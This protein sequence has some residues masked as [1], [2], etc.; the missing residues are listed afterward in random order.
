MTYPFNIL[1]KIV[2]HC[3]VQQQNALVLFIGLINKC[4]MIFCNSVYID[5]LIYYNSSN[6]FSI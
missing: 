5:I 2:L 1:H 3:I 6:L 4:H